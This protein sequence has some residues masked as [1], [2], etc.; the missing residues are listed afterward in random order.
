MHIKNQ[1]FSFILA[2]TLLISF[3]GCNSKPNEAVN[4]SSTIE[5]SFASEVSQ[6]EESEES[7]TTEQEN[8]LKS[9]TVGN[10]SFTYRDDLEMK[11]I[12]GV[13]YIYYNDT[14]F[15]YVESAQI[16]LGK[17]A[18]NEADAKEFFTASEKTFNEGDWTN[19]KMIT[20]IYKANFNG[21]DVW[22]CEM[23]MDHVSGLKFINSTAVLYLDGIL[24]SFTLIS[25][26]DSYQAYAIEFADTLT[27]ISAV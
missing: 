13:E 4:S 2:A 7:T 5:Q 11:D 21:L 9:D 25:D 19:G 1:L 8:V 3:S 23:E 27:S 12:D 26:I 15:F 18:I 17:E 24:T 16:A 22:I 6:K 10:I 20:E 14:S